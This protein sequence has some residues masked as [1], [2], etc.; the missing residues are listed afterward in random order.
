MKI[1]EL[2]INEIKQYG[3]NPRN[4]ESAVEMVAKSIKEYG[5]KVPILIDKNNEIIAGHTR[6]KA[7][8]QLG[9][10]TIPVIR[11]EDLT[12]EQVRG[13][14]IMDNKSHELASWDMDMLKSEIKELKELAFDTDLTG[15]TDTELS[16][17]DVEHLKFIEEKEFDENIK[18]ENICPKCGYKW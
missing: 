9:M 3:K 14:R 10:E 13:L 18:T 6:H 16:A 15:F 1:E 5:F 4:N 12:P 17:M 2:P 8:M 7:A 11:I